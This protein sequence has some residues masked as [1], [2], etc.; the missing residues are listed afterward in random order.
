MGG[1]ADRWVGGWHLSKTYGEERID[2]GHAKG[3]HDA[4][5]DRGLD[6]PGLERSKDTIYLPIEG[7]SASPAHAQASG[8]NER[9]R[10]RAGVH[11]ADQPT[12]MPI[13]ITNTKF[14][15]LSNA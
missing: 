8:E 12:P 4:D 7:R 9:E 10:E 3:R 5:E 2:K 11:T 6:A 1:D 13:V 15:P 14:Q